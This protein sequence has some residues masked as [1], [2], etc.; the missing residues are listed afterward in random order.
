MGDTKGE[1]P[2]Q[3]W[4]LRRD[5]I[6]FDIVWPPAEA[7]WGGGTTGG[8]AGPCVAKGFEFRFRRFWL[9]V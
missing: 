5:E 7:G 9:R 4:L 1:I 3:V 6:G 8:A 2:H